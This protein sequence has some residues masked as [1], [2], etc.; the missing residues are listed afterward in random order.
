MKI[1][2]SYASEQRELAK[3]IALALE[4]ETHTVF[5]D[6]SALAPGEAYNAQIREAFED[7]QLFVFLI[8]SDS[9]T[10]GRYTLTELAFAVGDGTVNPKSQYPSVPAC[11]DDSSTIRKYRSDGRSRGPPDAWTRMASS[12]PGIRNTL[13]RPTVVDC[14]RCWSRLVGL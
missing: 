3:E 9:V 11:W 6:R 14:F 2:L 10:A 5:F 12:G 7:S 4:A 1:F 13:A 8:S